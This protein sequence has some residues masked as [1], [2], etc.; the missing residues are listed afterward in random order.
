MLLF[1]A[2]WLH[3][4]QASTKPT[5]AAPL[6]LEG[7]GK[8]TV[9]LDGPWQFHTGDNPAWASP[10]FDSSHWQQLSADQ[11]W[12]KQ[13]HL[14]YTG[15]AWYRCDITVTPASGLPPQFSLLIPRIED[16]YEIYWN[17]SL[18]GRNG[19]LQPHPVWYYSQP[20]QTFALGQVQHGVLS[21][22]VWKAPR[23]SDDRGE[24]GGFDSAPLLGSPEAIAT[25]RDALEFQWLR[26]QQ[27]A[28]GEDLLCALIALL[29]FL[30]WLRARGRW[31][32][33]WTAGYALAPPLHL[34]FLKAHMGWPY[35]LAM[36]VDQPFGALRDISLWFLL[37]WLLRLHERRTLSR[38][39]RLLAGICLVNAT[40]DGVLV[41]LSGDPRWT[42]FIR[43][44]DALSTSLY[45]LLEAFPLVLVSYALWQRWHLDSARWLVAILTFLDEMLF[46]ARNIIKQGRQFTEWGIALRIDAPLFTLGGAAIS[47]ST[48]AE[49]LLL[50]AIVYAV[51]TSVREDQRRQ[52]VLERE[53]MELLR[54]SERMRHQAEHD[55]LTG[56][57]NH[58]MIVERLREEMNRA[59]RN[60]TPLCVVLIDVDHFK[61][62]NDN[63][64]HPAGDLV[65]QEVGAIFTR[66]LRPYDYAGRYG[67]EEFLL[68]LPGCGLETA[69]L[70][71]EQLRL[72][73][74]SAR[75]LDGETLL[76]VTASFGVASA[77]PS[78][79]DAET[80]IRAVDAALYRAK[81][82]G[83]NCVTPAI[84][85][86]MDIPLC[87]G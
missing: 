25:A 31:I 70:R 40:L 56:L 57:W 54:E 17:G 48:L 61:Q 33:F 52:E 86:E 49:A 83:R 77:F 79:E 58:R 11:P 23:L 15:F 12:G 39:T 10:S 47:L 59:R 78:Q 24:S 62:I 38:L 18:I 43:T 55:G 42:V 37:L 45:M 71:A 69:L 1:V 50:V 65:L 13:G 81:R 41:A 7:L 76:Q 6:V 75:I 19:K 20:P 60:E 84:P 72:A 82:S 22:R 32:L 3:A 63:F 53:K 46:F 4:M 27:F 74:Q 2:P 8:G 68:I 14:Q 73:V 44:A 30:L 64:G 51:Y 66:S 21:V 35:P 16:A 9:A 29:S 36:G 34:L 87:E 26:S 5:P 80:V 85:A 67:G 28:F